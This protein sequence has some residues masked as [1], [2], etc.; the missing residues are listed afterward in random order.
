MEQLIQARIDSLR[1]F[2]QK[3]GDKI[4]AS[5][6]EIDTQK[7]QLAQALA[8]LG[9]LENRIKGGTDPGPDPNDII[10]IIANEYLIPGDTAEFEAYLPDNSRVKTVDFY[11][12]GEK[13][14]TERQAPFN[15]W[16]TIPAADSL[17]VRAVFNLKD[18]TT[19]EATQTFMT[20]AAP[21]PE[22][23]LIDMADI[24]VVHIDG[25]WGDPDDI[26]SQSTIAALLNAADVE[27]SSYFFV[28]NN[29]QEQDIDW[30]VESLRAGIEYARKLGITCFDYTEDEQAT[31]DQLVGLFNT[32]LKV[33]SLEAG[34]MHSVYDALQRTPTHLHKNI[35]LV[36]HHPWND[37]FDSTGEGKTW[38]GL[39]AAFPGVTYIHIPDQNPGFYSDAWNWLD[40]ATAPELVECRRVMRMAGAKQQSKQNDASDFGLAWFAITA[41]QRGTVADVKQFLT[42][43]QP[44]F[45][46]GSA[47]TVP[48]FVE[49][50][51]GLYAIDAIHLQDDSKGWKQDDSDGATGEGSIVFLGALSDQTPTEDTIVGAT[52]EVETAG[53]YQLHVRTING[54]T[55]ANEGDQNSSWIGL[56][57]GDIFATPQ[58]GTG[59]EDTPGPLT[60]DMLEFSSGEHQQFSHE[61]KT[62][63]GY[64]IFAALEPG[65]QYTVLIAGR[66]PGHIIDFIFARHT[67]L[68]DESRIDKYLQTLSGGGP[69]QGGGG[70]IDPPL[71][72]TAVAHYESFVAKATGTYYDMNA[73]L[74]ELG[75]CSEAQLE[76][77]FNTGA[78]HMGSPSNRARIVE[79]PGLP[80]RKAFT[81]EMGPSSA[82]FGNR[83]STHKT[84][85]G[86][87][88]FYPRAKAVASYTEFMHATQGDYTITMDKHVKTSSITTVDGPPEPGSNSTNGQLRTSQPGRAEA[89]RFCYYHSGSQTS[90][91][92]K[93]DLGARHAGQPTWWRKEDEASLSKPADM[94]RKKIVGGAFYAAEPMTYDFQNMLYSMVPD[95][96]GQPTAERFML[97]SDELI[98]SWIILEPNTVQ[99]DGTPDANGTYHWYLQID[100]MN[101]G[102]PF[103]AAVLENFRFTQGKPM[104]IDSVSLGAYF[105]SS[106]KPSEANHIL[107]LRDLVHYEAA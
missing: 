42:D 79:V 78:V 84:N 21:M 98:R 93:G 101:G 71:P 17:Q 90:P 41:D 91:D 10:T 70:P 53:I 66:Q 73:D 9:D 8:D 100:S 95:Q 24:L 7:Q 55:A 61:T 65:T 89:G 92:K 15:S 14:N 12:N 104:I 74:E 88:T 86:D 58:L 3:L 60:L 62:P 54:D 85:A 6:T 99:A 4:Q 76:R 20:Q 51:P 32:G 29:R 50:V 106:D 57:G 103:L 35:T 27:G 46:K 5:R 43:N 40:T 39:Q 25:N 49:A 75:V 26:G 2:L 82:G 18:G 28:G 64:S 77:M 22:A 52:L 105:N 83:F 81:W 44:V 11:I 37:N 34:P 13:E 36:S 96:N 63:D 87:S 38:E 94:R 1:E 59:V 16:P 23:P 68:A 33:V 48:A 97:P 107:V 56:D 45:L 80:G 47:T 31:Q 102:E 30:Q 19:L 67:D 72:D 69:G